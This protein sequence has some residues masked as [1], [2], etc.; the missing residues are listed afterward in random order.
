MKR[1]ME[2][3]GLERVAEMGL[4][5]FVIIKRW[6]PARPKTLSSSCPSS[7]PKLSLK[8]QKSLT[9]CHFIAWCGDLAPSPLGFLSA[10]HLPFVQCLARLVPAPAKETDWRPCCSF[11]SRAGLAR[12]AAP[13][14]RNLEPSIQVRYW[15]TNQS[16]I[17]AGHPPH[18]RTPTQAKT[19]PEDTD[20]LPFI[21]DTHPSSIWHS[22]PVPTYHLTTPTITILCR[23]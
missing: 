3:V 9:S 11:A 17:P 22:H 13:S 1:A 6:K 18:F 4:G 23:P 5:L 12:S 19:P 15:H 8:I 21:Q 2:E 14:T 16:R 7:L 10:V 20:F